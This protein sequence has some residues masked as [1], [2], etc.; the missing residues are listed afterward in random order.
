[1][2]DHGWFRV[3]VVSLMLGAW[4]LAD[5]VGR[6]AAW[7]QRPRGGWRPL[8]SHAL[9]FASVILLFSLTAATGR[10]IEAGMVNQIGI[11]LALLA[12]VLRVA[13]R[14]GGHVL[15]YP[16]L[17]ARLACFA[18][19]PLAAGAPAAWLAFTLPQAIVAAQE[20][21]RRDRVA[22]KGGA[23]ASPPGRRILPG[24]W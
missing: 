13:Y 20:A 3:I 23:T 6:V 8:W 14:R 18:A 24:L 2:F 7:R 22:A 12:A 10:A 16:D 17:T 1:M 11:A 4:G 19:I 5:F 9:G 21:V 15:R